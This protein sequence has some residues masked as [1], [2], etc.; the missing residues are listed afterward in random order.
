MVVE[1]EVGWKRMKSRIRR[2]IRE[3]NGMREY[4]NCG[5]VEKGERHMLVYERE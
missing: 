1:E 3:G 4:K 5:R 2:N